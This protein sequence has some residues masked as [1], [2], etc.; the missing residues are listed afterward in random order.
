MACGNSFTA[1]PSDA[2]GDGSLPDGPTAETGGGDAEAGAEGGP[3]EGGDGAAGGHIVYV[4]PSGDDTAAGLD[5]AH[6]KKTVTAG[7]AAAK[8]LPG[9]PEVHVCKGTYTED[10]VLVDFDVKL[11][12][13]YDCTTWTQTAT[14]GYPHPDG[15]DLT[16]LASPDTTAQ[17]AAIFVTGPVTHATVI[18]GLTITGAPTTSAHTDGVRVTG[19]ASPILSNDVIAGGSGQ[20]AASTGATGSV[21]ILVDTQA[22]PEIEGCFVSGGLG[23]GTVGSTGVVLDS[24]GGVSLHD[25]VATGGTGQTSVTSGASAIGVDV[26]TALTT[27]LSSLIVSGTDQAGTNGQSIGVRI[28]GASVTAVVAGSF[29]EGGS[30]LDTSAGSVGLV[31]DAPGGG[32]TLSGD[33]VYGGQRTFGLQQTI[34]VFVAAAGSLTI[35]NT[36]VHGGTVQSASGAFT[37]GI[38][39]YAVA[40]PILAFD[41]VYT[42]SAAGT[43]IAFNPGVTGALIR[44]DLVLGSD[45]TTGSIGVATTACTGMIASLDHTAF[46]NVQLLYQCVNAGGT[47]T[48]AANLVELGLALGAAESND[49]AVQSACVSADTTCATFV[50]CPGTSAACLPGI[51]G[52]TWSS[53]DGIS[54][55]FG[56]SAAE[57][58]A[59]VQGWTLVPGAACTIASGGTAYGGVTADVY[60]AKRALATPTMGAVEY[61]GA[62]KCSAN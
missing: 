12:G 49:V 24:T 29:I 15:V 42:G 61:A 31:I 52:A 22:A 59:P 41:T 10:G 60:G 9:L 28:A 23:R 3:T 21:G 44:D 40:S 11:K 48:Q 33:R 26:R 43:A 18:D 20:A 32:V 30:G 38:D 54:A 47:A 17:E 58:G 46:G 35:E 55:L 62:P 25:S 16:L 7:L 51:F 39:L 36:L 6:P 53:D 8:V 13:A 56:Q 34:G 50:G 2:G 57:G 27:P 37:V 14:Y 19:S 1:G 4:S 5:P 45:A